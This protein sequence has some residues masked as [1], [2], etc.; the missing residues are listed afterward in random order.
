[1]G[2][3]L[4]SVFHQCPEIMLCCLSD[5][6][7]NV[8]ST[9]NRVSNILVTMQVAHGYWTYCTGHFIRYVTIESLCY[10]PEANIILYV[11]SN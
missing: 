7:L 1:M 5:A 10:T 8:Y 4:D 9:G 11:N 2:I 3:G 6:N